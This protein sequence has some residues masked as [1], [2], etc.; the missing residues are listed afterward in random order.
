MCYFNE[1]L[2]TCITRKKYSPMY[3][4]TLRFSEVSVYSNMTRQIPIRE[5]GSLNWHTFTHTHTHT[6]THKYISTTCILSSGLLKPI[7]HPL[8][9][10]KSVTSTLSHNDNNI[11]ELITLDWD[12][13]NT[14]LNKNSKPIR[15]RS[16][17]YS[18]KLGTQPFV[19]IMFQLYA[20]P[21][22]KR[23]VRVRSIH[24]PSEYPNRMPTAHLLR[25]RLVAQHIGLVASE[26]HLRRRPSLYHRDVLVHAAFIHEEVALDVKNGWRKDNNPLNFKQG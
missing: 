23:P 2:W 8:T 14:Q 11:D 19:I 3:F 13:T 21:I 24:T 9:N 16:N 22:F 12:L 1:A 15:L 26:Y 20:Y 10:P 4:P 17:R 7:F 18:A 25:N 6:H 5:T